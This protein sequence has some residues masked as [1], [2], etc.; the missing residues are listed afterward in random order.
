MAVDAPLGQP[1]RG[2]PNSMLHGNASHHAP[3]TT[4][5]PEST[6]CSQHG[7]QFMQRMPSWRIDPIRP[8]L[9]M[10]TGTTCL[11]W[12]AL[13]ST[14]RPTHPSLTPA[15][16]Q[17]T[18]AAPQRRPPDSQQST[19]TAS[20]RRPPDSQQSTLTAPKRRPLDSQQ[21][22]LTAPKRQPPDDP[23]GPHPRGRP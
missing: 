3:T 21:S 23:P 6:N 16:Q 22:T 15:T 20:K 5:H 4:K 13:L 7:Q 11:R 12:F 10:W 18:L 14:R 1:T 8:V 9:G 17:P 19:L 2:P